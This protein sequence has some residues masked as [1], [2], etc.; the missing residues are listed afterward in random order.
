MTLTLWYVERAVTVVLN[1]GFEIVDD[2]TFFRL[3]WG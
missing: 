1:G 3:L 2:V